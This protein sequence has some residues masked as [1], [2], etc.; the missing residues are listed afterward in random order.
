MTA[1][2]QA[3]RIA[4]AAVTGANDK[5]GQDIVVLDVSQKL[6]IADVFVIVSGGNERQV[7]AIVDEVE[8]R[9]LE[10]G[11][12]PARREGDREDP[13]VL[14]DYFDTIVHVQHTEARQMYGLDRL[15]KDC[16]EVA[17]GSVAG[18]GGGTT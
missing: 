7:S 12:A 2:D 16:P 10:S 9:C 18:V 11:F 1:S 4:R 13:W 14:L 5:L 6:G 3:L 15:W 8:R 17:M